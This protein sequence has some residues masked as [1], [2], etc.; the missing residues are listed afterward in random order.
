MRKPRIKR[1]EC[2]V[3]YLGDPDWV[4]TLVDSIMGP[5]PVAEG[6]ATRWSCP[7]GEVKRVITSVKEGDDA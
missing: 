3:I 2:T 5:V 6:Q 4:D 1:V 7:Q